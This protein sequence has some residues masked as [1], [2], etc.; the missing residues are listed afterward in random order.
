MSVIHVTVCYARRN[1]DKTVQF[2]VIV[3]KNSRYMTNLRY[4]TN[5]NYLSSKHVSFVYT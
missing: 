4:R 2:R 3:S 1:C 5:T